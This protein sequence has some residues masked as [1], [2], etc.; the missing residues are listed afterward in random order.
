MSREADIWWN[1]VKSRLV[2]PKFTWTK[3]LND[4]RATFYPVVV[5]RQKVKEFIEVRMS[6]N[7][8]VMQHA[9]KFTKLSRFALNLCHLKG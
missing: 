7:M 2:G 8:T 3:F 9:S 6:G 5:Q 4:L 1:T